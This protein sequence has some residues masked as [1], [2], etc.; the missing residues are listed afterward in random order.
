M[1]PTH[2][3]VMCACRRSAAGAVLV[4]DAQPVLG[5]LAARG[6]PLG[7]VALRA[8]TNSFLCKTARQEGQRTAEG[9]PSL[10]K[11]TD[12]LGLEVAAAHLASTDERGERSRL[13]RRLHRR[14]GIVSTLQSSPWSS[15]AVRPTLRIVDLPGNW[16]PARGARP[17]AAGPQPPVLNRRTSPDATSIN[18]PPTGADKGYDTRAFV[19][20]VRARGVTPHVAQNTANRRSAIDGRTTRHGGYAVSQKKRKLVE[21]GFGWKK[22][23]GLL[24]KLRHRGIERVE[25][26]YTFT[27]AA[28]NLVRMRSLLLEA[29]SP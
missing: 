17:A 2:T 8:V 28:F 23:V 10:E 7:L 21:Q 4:R 24:R 16:A 26:I 3:A 18:V 5:K 22:S 14:F 27:S 9:N 11:L 1:I 15:G 12:W 25:W 29:V 6:P 19:A 20:G 13:R